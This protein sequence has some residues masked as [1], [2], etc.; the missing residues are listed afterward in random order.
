MWNSRS[1]VNKL[2]CFQ[3]FI[4]AHD[5]SFI[6]LTETWL[7][8][9]IYNNELLPTGYTIYRKDRSSKGGGVMLAVKSAL[10]STQLPAPDNL[11]VVTISV[12]AHCSLT[13]CAVYTP[14]NSKND[15][16][17]G[18]YLYLSTL[19]SSANVILLGDFNAPD[20]NWDTFISTNTIS[21]HLCDFIIDHNMFQQV[22]KPTHI[23]G[24]ILDL[25]ITSDPDLT[26]DLVIHP[27]TTYPLQSDHFIIT[28]SICADVHHYKCSRNV[29]RPT[30]DLNKADWHNINRFFT[31]K[32]GDAHFYSTDVETAWA[33]LKD[34]LFHV[35][36]TYIPKKRHHS[37]LRPQWFT[38][39]IQNHLNKLHTLRKKVKRNPTEHNKHNLKAAENVLQQLILS[40]RQ[41]YESALI[42][43][44]S[45]SNSNNIY[46]FMSSLTSS[47]SIPTTMFLDSNTLNDDSSIS[48][49]FNNQFLP[50]VQ[51]TNH[52][53]LIV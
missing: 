28:F 52:Q 36:A 29:S 10:K 14:P 53:P 13:I 20:V 37:Q 26:T 51:L 22:N 8:D 9:H 47:R 7:H 32:N 31:F 17:Q 23:H 42:D 5:Y 25:V 41:T 50:R 18:L 49:G 38:S 30:Y 39:E 24:N 46:K 3:S 12:Q 21:D 27:H 1:I 15:Y 33:S 40:A 4:Y 48:N 35:M 34:L 44:F 45:K 6:A 16:I 11:E 2:R 19:I 43:Q